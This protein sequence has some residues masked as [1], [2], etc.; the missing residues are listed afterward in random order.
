V[1]GL[2][3]LGDEGAGVADV[4]V[5]RRWRGA[6]W[7]CWGDGGG[8]LLDFVGVWGEGGKR[9]KEAREEG[10]EDGKTAARAKAGAQS[11]K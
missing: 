1:E 8:V 7:P 9:E 10:G 6:S 2:G 3:E 11:Q 5:R 4:K